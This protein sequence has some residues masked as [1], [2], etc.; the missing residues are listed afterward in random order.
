MTVGRDAPNL[1]T[2][3]DSLGS[4]WPGSYWP[5]AIASARVWRIRSCFESEDSAGVSVI[6]A[7]DNTGLSLSKQLQITLDTTE[8][9]GYIA[10]PMA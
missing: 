7:P 1:L 10:P 4:R 9:S 3:S 2:S 6:T 8:L 5:D